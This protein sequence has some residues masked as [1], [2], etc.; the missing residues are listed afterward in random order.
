MNTSYI[1]QRLV[2]AIGVILG[3]TIIVFA[4]V[5]AVPGDPARIAMGTSASEEAV[6]ARR[7]AMGLNDPFFIQYGRWLG[8][9]IQLDFGNSLLTGASVSDQV[10]QRLPA[11]LQLAGLAL[12]IGLTIPFPL[13]IISA[14]RPGSKLDTTASVV[15]QIG[16]ALPDF[17]MSILLVLV[18]SS[19]LDLLPPLGYTPIGENFGE[20]LSHMILPATTAGLISASI[21]TRFIR[22][23]MLEVMNKSYIQT[24]RAKG[25]RERTIVYRHALR[26]TMIT[27]VTIIGLQVTALI[28]SVVVI[29]IVF[30]LPGLG[31]LALDAVL[32]RDYPLLQGAVLVMATLVTLVNLS[33]DLLYLWLDPRIDY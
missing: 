3:V 10:S 19:A 27:V 4:I 16:I 14:L 2:L 21:L 30:D 31:K 33:V 13:G 25:L 32:S 26:N 17:W 7:E 29:E 11:T 6:E 1:L 15:S 12:L 5:Q 8:D 22:S 9:A 18:F 20:W 28:S 23:A 24:A